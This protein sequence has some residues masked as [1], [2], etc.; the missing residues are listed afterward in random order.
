MFKKYLVE[1][2][3][4]ILLV[5]IILAAKNPIATGAIFGLI[6]MFTSKISNGYLNPAITIVMSALGRIDPSEILPYCLSQVFG[7]LVA[8]ELYKRTTM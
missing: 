7:A 2:T 1:F 6:V 3:G 5:Y 8:F 4:S